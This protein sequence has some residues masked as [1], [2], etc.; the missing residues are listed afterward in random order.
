MQISC[1]ITSISLTV[2]NCMKASIDPRSL[3]NTLNMYQRMAGCVWFKFHCCKLSVMGHWYSEIPR[4]VT[5]EWDIVGLDSTE[6][7]HCIQN[8]PLYFQLM[9]HY[10]SYWHSIDHYLSV[11]QYVEGDISSD[12]GDYDST[13]LRVYHGRSDTDNMGSS[14]DTSWHANFKRIPFGQCANQ[15]YLPPGNGYPPSR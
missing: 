7:H 10:K 14:D 13:E 12:A 5:T 2:V 9:L 4:F 15:F 11:T 8:T 6:G 1:D 3:V